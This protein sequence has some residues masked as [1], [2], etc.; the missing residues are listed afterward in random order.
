[1]R[2]GEH[3]GKVDTDRVRV[4]FTKDI[5]R[6][7]PTQRESGTIVPTTPSSG[8]GVRIVR[9]DGTPIYEGGGK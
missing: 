7:V 8:G 6:G 3:H 9:G 5:K 2:P 1:M 4:E